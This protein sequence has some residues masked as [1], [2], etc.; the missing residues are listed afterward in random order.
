MRIVTED[1]F[2]AHCLA[3]ATKRDGLARLPAASL[4]RPRAPRSFLPRTARLS[5]VKGGEQL[6][7][8][9]REQRR[10]ALAVWSSRLDPCSE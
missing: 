8:G 6:V 4:R 2:R 9:E 10:Q 7:V 3:G 5:C 1:R